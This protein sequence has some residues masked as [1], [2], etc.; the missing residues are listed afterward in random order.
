VALFVAAWRR[1]V[2]LTI[3]EIYDE[4]QPEAAYKLKLRI[5]LRNDSRFI[6]ELRKP[7]WLRRSESDLFHQTPL[8]SS[9]E[10]EEAEQGLRRWSRETEVAVVRPGQRC[11]VWVGMD[12]TRCGPADLRTRI[13]T[14]LQLGT[15]EFPANAA[16]RDRK[17]EVLVQTP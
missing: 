6:L 4:Q 9:F 12:A 1:R 15:L 13:E 8:G 14:K 11:R 2:T 16:G 10:L 3:A 5:V 17:L 7:R